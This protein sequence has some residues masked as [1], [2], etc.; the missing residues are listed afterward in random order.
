MIKVF[1]PWLKWL[2]VDLLPR[3]PDFNPRPILGWSVLKKLAPTEDFKEY[4]LSFHRRSI[5]TNPFIHCHALQSRQLSVFKQHTKMIKAILTGSRYF[6][7]L[8]TKISDNLYLR[9]GNPSLRHVGY[10]VGFRFFMCL[11]DLIL[12]ITY[13]KTFHSIN[14]GGLHNINK[15][16]NVE[17]NSYIFP[18]VLLA[19]V[20]K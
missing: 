17:W 4:I 13:L 6:I 5:L 19:I 20:Y 12:M 10:W 18:V 1:V 7:I 14:N 15:Y 9:L 8:H 16:A 11:C 2:M 3:S